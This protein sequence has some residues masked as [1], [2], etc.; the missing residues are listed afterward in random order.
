[1]VT[2]V[3]IVM[4]IIINPESP[5]LVVTCKLALAVASSSDVLHSSHMLTN[6]P[7]APTVVSY[8]GPPPSYRSQSCDVNNCFCYQIKMNDHIFTY[9][10]TLEIHLIC[11]LKSQPSICH[12]S[13]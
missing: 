12:L 3:I 9:Q 11:N 2:I 4:R 10:A 8:Q 13:V 1:M 6:S 5:D 7:A